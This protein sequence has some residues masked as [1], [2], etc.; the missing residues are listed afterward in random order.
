M[1]RIILKSLLISI[2]GVFIID[3]FFHILFS[4]P[5]ETTEYFFTKAFA[6]FIFSII[7]LKYT[8]GKI[9]SFL[10]VFFGGVIIASLWGM[11]YNVFPIIFD[12]YPY[13]ISLEGLSFLGM[14]IIGTG[15]SFGIVHTAAF[16]G[17]Y[18]T[19]KI[20]IK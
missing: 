10:K 5:M 3:Y 19:S 7:F 2:V 14:G 1:F 20:I 13:G 18:Y 6:Y 9:T 12:Y 4:S 8:N 16:V 17:G 15:I 11:Y